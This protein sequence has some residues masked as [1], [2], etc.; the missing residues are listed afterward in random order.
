MTHKFHEINEHCSKDKIGYSWRIGGKLDI[1]VESK[2]HIVIKP[3]K[4]I[5]VRTIN[6]NGKMCSTIMTTPY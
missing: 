1:K 2:L 6:N 4:P 3:P 5:L